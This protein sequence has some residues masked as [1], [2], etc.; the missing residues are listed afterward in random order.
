VEAEEVQLCALKRFWRMKI[1][2]RTKRHDADDKA[3]LC[4]TLISACS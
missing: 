3:R 4:D 2:I 1:R